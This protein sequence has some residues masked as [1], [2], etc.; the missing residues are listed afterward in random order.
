M[1]L[2][3]IVM[4]GSPRELAADDRLQAAYLGRGQHSR[5]AR[6]Q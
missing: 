2:G 6:L 4:H 5:E 3:R 1:E